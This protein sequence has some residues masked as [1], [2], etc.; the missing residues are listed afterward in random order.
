MA[1]L[2]WDKTEERWYSAGVDRGLIYALEAYDWANQCVVWNGLVSVT[3]TQQRE[4]KSYYQDGVKLLERLSSKD[5]SAKIEA[6]TYP[7]VMDQ[8]IGN[9]LAFSGVSLHDQRPLRF[10]LSYRTRIGDAHSQDL[11]YRLHLVFNLVANADD[12]EFKTL[13]DD[14]SAEP[15]GW[16]VSATPLWWSDRWVS[17]ISIDSRYANPTAL[18][19]LENTLYGTP[20]SDP[21]W[22]SLDLLN[23]FS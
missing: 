6:F 22:P 13:S 9:E 2:E 15:F 16:T 20:T 21:A 3:E 10:H 8:L 23:N 1:V 18:A 19:D 11:G 14:A 12:T 5:Y 4:S 17:H 7:Q